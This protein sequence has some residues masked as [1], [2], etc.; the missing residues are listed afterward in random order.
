MKTKRTSLLVILLM[1]V[2]LTGCKESKE[3]KTFKESFD[4]FCTNVAELDASINSID[5]N[6]EDA[7]SQLLTLLDELDIQFQQLAALEIPKQ[8]DYLEN[9][10]DEASE[11]MTLAVENYHTAFEAEIYDTDAANLAA[12]YYERAYK[13]VQYIIT[14]LQGDVPDD[15]NVQITEE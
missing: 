10:A 1:A 11:N 15:E 3:L 12:G 4:T 13:R 6:A 9:L 8:F 5:A 7:S 2:L 14:F